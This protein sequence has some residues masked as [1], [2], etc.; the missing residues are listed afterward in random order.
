MKA[1]AAFALS[2]LTLVLGTA[3]LATGASQDT[4][5]TAAALAEI[6]A[7]LLPVY[8]RAAQTCEGLPWPVLAAIGYFESRHAAGRSDPNTGDVTPPIIGA[9]L[10]GQGGR[11]RI[12]DASSSDG[13]M[14]AL[15]PM[16]FLPTMWRTWATLAPNR[17]P[18]ASPSPQNAWD[19]IYTAAAY[20]CR[21]S[22]QLADLRAAVDSYA[23]S[24][25]YYPRVIAK[26]TEYGLGQVTP[27]GD[28]GAAAVAIAMREL[29]VQYVYGAASPEHGF[30]C[31]G[32]VYWAYAQVGVQI[33]RVTYDQVRIG[34]A[35]ALPDIR[36]GDLIFTRGDVPTRDYGHVA[37]Y[38]G[39]GIE[40]NA[41]H[42]GAVVSLR[43]VA[44]E[45]VQ[46]VRRIGN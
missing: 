43:P 42:T 24:S 4:Q 16:Q 46:A 27:T 31:S 7:S 35:V 13:W 23:G 18:G 8:Q 39:N 21:G 32:L 45:R 15:G 40:I 34:T 37:M 44:P 26:A 19:A 5:P 6:P 11:A 17:A 25:D 10:D 20:L 3:A 30:D 38:V 14:H 12:T 29:G 36:A 1:I 2:A 28:L 9:P 33:P 41:P 22:H